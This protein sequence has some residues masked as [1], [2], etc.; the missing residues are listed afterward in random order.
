MAK[1]KNKNKSKRWL[2]RFGTKQERANV[3]GRP[4]T[5]KSLVQ[6]QA[7]KY[8]YPHSHSAVA[9]KSQSRMYRDP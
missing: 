5:L 6:P 7:P 2:S 9:A 1:S 3:N 4:K 8:R